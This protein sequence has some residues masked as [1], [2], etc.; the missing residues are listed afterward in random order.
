M[1]LDV[2]LPAGYTVGTV[3]NEGL[4]NLGRNAT[5]EVIGW[6]INHYN[7]PGVMR[8][9]KDGNALAIREVD[10]SVLFKKKEERKR[11]TRRIQIVKP[12]RRMTPI[13]RLSGKPIG[14]PLKPVNA[15]VIERL[16]RMGLLTPEEA[17]EIFGPK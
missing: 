12:A 13:P 14:R 11:A 1:K 9:I 8:Y 10:P 4:K 15:V 3:H 2:T 7:E 6:Y 16:I 5:F 17:T